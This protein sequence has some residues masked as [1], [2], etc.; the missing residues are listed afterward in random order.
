MHSQLTCTHCHAAKVAWLSDV[1]MSDGLK[2]VN[3]KA[4][5]MIALHEDHQPLQ[6][7]G[8]CCFFRLTQVATNEAQR[9]GRPLPGASNTADT[10]PS[11]ALYAPV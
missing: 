9:L 5:G 7:C 2:A 6:S 11:S 3:W 4:M 8:A 10:A 1:S